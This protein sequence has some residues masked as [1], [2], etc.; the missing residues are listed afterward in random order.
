MVKIV[1]SFATSTVVQTKKEFIS[2]KMYGLKTL[3]YNKQQSDEK[4]ISI[5]SINPAR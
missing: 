3:L 1:Q 4:D 2:K 5:N